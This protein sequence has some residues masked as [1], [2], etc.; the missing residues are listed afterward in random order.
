MADTEPA[1]RAGLSGAR[2]APAVDGEAAFVAVQ[3]GVFRLEAPLTFAT[4]PLLRAPGVQRIAAASGA[5][6]FNLERV[7]TLDSAGLALLIDWLAEARR[8]QRTLRYGQPPEALLQL[9]QLSEVESLI[10]GQEAASAAPPH[11]SDSGR[12]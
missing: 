12:S 5:L 4:V 6:Q 9:A 8:R 1:R 3:N 7:V 2:S 10:A 11:G